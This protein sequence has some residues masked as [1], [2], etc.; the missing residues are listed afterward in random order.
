M[1][2]FPQLLF[3]VP[4]GVILLLAI[5]FGEKRERRVA[6]VILVAV[7]YICFRVFLRMWLKSSN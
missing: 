5:C 4:A 3:I 6:L 7:A 2:Y 1:K